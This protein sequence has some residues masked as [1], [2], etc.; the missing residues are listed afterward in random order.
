[1]PYSS[2]TQCRPSV[3]KSVLRSGSHIVRNLKSSEPQIALDYAVWQG[4]VSTTFFTTHIFLATGLP[5][6]LQVRISFSFL[7]RDQNRN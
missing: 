2:Q 3:S 1:M 4:R 6:L 7:I 5:E